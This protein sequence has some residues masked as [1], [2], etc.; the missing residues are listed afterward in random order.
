MYIVGAKTATFFMGCVG[1]LLSM[2]IFVK[3]KKLDSA[4]D[5]EPT[6]THDDSTSSESVAA[7]V[8]EE[9]EPEIIPEVEIK[10]D[11]EQKTNKENED[12]LSPFEEFIAWLDSKK[13][14]PKPIENNI[15][16]SPE[17]EDKQASR[18]SADEKKEVPKKIIK[19]L[20]KILIVFSILIVIAGIGVGG[21]FAY[22]YYKHT[23]LPKKYLK[24]TCAELENQW[25]NAEGQDKIDLAVKI[26]T[27]DATW[28]YEQVPDS[29]IYENFAKEKYDA[30]LK[31]IE[32]DAF[33]GNADSQFLLGQLY[34][35]ENK[36]YVALNYTKAAY[37]WKEAATNGN[38]H[39]MCNLGWA[40]RKGNGVN[41][42]IIKAI[43][44]YQKAAEGNIDEAIYMLGWCYKNGVKVESG[45]HYEQYRVRG[46]DN[47][48]SY[49]DIFV[50]TI[51]VDYDRYEV[52]K[53]KVTDYKIIIP[54]DVNKAK[55]LWQR[56]ASL[57]HEDART[58]IQ[59]IFE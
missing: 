39:A 54:K 50:K 7:I 21:Y 49:N 42:N 24:E 11:E 56:A 53:H 6:Q 33:L 31:V 18:M 57:G 40:Y 26:L 23:Y 48:R 51:W 4:L 17:A 32:N 38:M 13:N 25:N 34:G 2:L 19:I 12:E 41:K 59:R 8:L 16:S 46:Y 44:C 20:K 45:Y 5:N 30:A 1:L 10:Q 9:P 14:H 27:I 58:E 29:A 28:N 36:Y 47:P 35:I 22:D 3:V 52:Y 43:E 15:D 37:W 55:E